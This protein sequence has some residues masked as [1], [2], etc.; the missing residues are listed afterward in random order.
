MALPA[1]GQLGVDLVRQD[2]HIGA[3]QHLG[4]GF[5][6]FPLHHRAGGVVGVRQDQQLGAGGDGIFQLFG[7]ETEL[8]LRPGGNVHRHA[9]GEGCDGLVTDKAGFRDDDL[10]PRLDHGADGHIDGL[11]AAHRDQHLVIR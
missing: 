10:V 1:V 8:V 4:D 2:H 3:A 11:A 5:Q 9:A 6:V 7:L